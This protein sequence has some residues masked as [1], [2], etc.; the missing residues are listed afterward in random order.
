LFFLIYNSIRKKKKKKFVKILKY[1]LKYRFKLWRI[2]KKTNILYNM[3]LGKTFLLKSLN[4]QLILYFPIVLL[5]RNGYL[6]KKLI[7]VK[8]KKRKKF[9]KKSKIIYLKL[10]LLK[11]FLERYFLYF[12]KVNLS[13]YFIDTNAIMQNSLLHQKNLLS[14]NTTKLFGRKLKKDF[15]FKK[16]IFIANAAYYLNDPILMLRQL[17]ERLTK[18]R[19]HKFA[20]KQYFKTLYATRPINPA[21]LGVHILLCGKFNGK[22]RT[23][24]TK[25][26]LGKPKAVQTLS[27]AVSYAYT[28]VP[29]YTGIFGMH[30]WYIF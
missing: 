7:F 17:S 25:F 21:I 2:E 11:N 23:K 12:E 20:L 10:F 29:T 30:I 14:L 27:N 26:R 1:K 15:I 8:K 28:S 22:R 19:K 4:Q 18:L 6:P 13:L 5:Y 24:S 9:F 16:L 3:Q